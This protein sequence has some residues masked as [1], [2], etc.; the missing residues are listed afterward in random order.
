MG[1]MVTHMMPNLISKLGACYAYCPFQYSDM[2]LYFL[3]NDLVL[4]THR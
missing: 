3:D 1:H 2:D 4:I